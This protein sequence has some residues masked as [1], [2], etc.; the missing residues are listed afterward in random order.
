MDQRFVAS[1]IYGAAPSTQPTA[2][3]TPDH[4]TAEPEPVVRSTPLRAPKSLGVDNPVL[5]L[6]VVLGLVVLLVQLSI[7]VEIDA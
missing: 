1:T 4:G 3:P 2:T 5:V 6:V 7:R